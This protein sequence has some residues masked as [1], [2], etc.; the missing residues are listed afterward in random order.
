[1]FGSG[2]GKRRLNS[3]ASDEKKFKAKSSLLNALDVTVVKT[4]T[5]YKAFLARDENT[6]GIGQ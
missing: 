1:M 2:I 5:G 3:K 6:W 4:V